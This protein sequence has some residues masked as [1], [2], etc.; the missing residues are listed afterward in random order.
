V[1][2]LFGS[3]DDQRLAPQTR[4]VGIA[5]ETGDGTPAAVVRDELAAACVL[6]LRVGDT[7][8]VAWHRPGQASALDT[9]DVSGG[10]D[11]GTVGVFLPELDGQ[12]LTF[13]A[14]QEGF[15]DGE[16]GTTWNVLGS[17]PAGHSKA[18]S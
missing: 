17:P 10:R 18:N 7:Q 3:P 8:L 9:D 11:I 14:S 1:R 2:P 15:S 5:D 4:V 13:T 12:R 6:E 16:T